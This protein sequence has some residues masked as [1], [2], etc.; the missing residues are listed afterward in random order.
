[1]PPLSARVLAT[2]APVIADVRALVESV[3]GCLS[4]AQGAVHWAPP[5]AALDAA[6]TAA[7]D[8][9]TSFYGPDLGTPSLRGAV[10]AALVRDHGLDGSRYRVAIT[11][12][13]NMAVGALALALLD[14]GDAALSY[15]PAYFNADM[16]VQLAG[17]VVEHVACDAGWRPDVAATRARLA[18][19]SKPPVRAVYLV[20]PGNPSGVTVPRAVVDDLVAAAAAAG[21]WL[22]LDG[23]YAAFAPPGDAAFRLPSA[24]HVIHV[25]SF[26]KAYGAAGWRV[27]WIA[28][29]VEA[30]AAA[31]SDDAD[32]LSGALLKILDTL[33]I[34]AAHASQALA[35]ACL[36]AA[37]PA[38]VA[39][40]VAALAPSRA[41]ARAAL[42]PLH[43]HVWGG[44][45][46]Y[47]WA[48]LPPGCEDDWRVVRWMAAAHRVAVVPG[49]ACGTPGHVRVAFAKPAPGPEF[50]EAARRLGAACRV[51]VERGVAVVDAWEREER[52]KER[53]GGG[54]VMG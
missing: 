26:S 14:P 29:P 45:A 15:A 37:G 47:W 12:G 13:A 53:R 38:W 16:A 3:P 28:D 1:M 22:V 4:L 8:P 51:L 20:N 35:A 31:P 43:P 49:S 32:P 27:G 44:D 2:D 30:G 34:H 41:A 42:A 46:I 17:G 11:P 23:T 54:D 25:G 36:S 40:R 33:P 18:D 52:E 6:A 10:L 19:P 7:A 39:D 9:A 50:E 24:P 5:P 48:R 21:V